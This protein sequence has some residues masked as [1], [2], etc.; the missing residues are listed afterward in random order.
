MATGEFNLSDEVTLYAEA[1]FN[2][3]ESKH[4]YLTQMWGYNYTSNWALHPGGEACS[5]VYDGN[6][7]DC[8]DYDY[9]SY[10]YVDVGNGDP[11][12]V[13]WT[14]IFWMAAGGYAQ[15][16]QVNTQVDYSR[17][18]LGSLGEIG[19][20]DWDFDVSFQYSNSAGKY[21]DQVPLNDAW[22][23][24]SNTVALWG[25]NHV[26]SCEGMTFDRY[27]PDGEIREADIACVDFN[28]LDPRIMA[29]NYTDE[30]SAFMFAEEKGTTDYTNMAL[31]IGFTNNELFT[32]Y[33]G[34]IGLAVGAQFM[35]DE[36]DDTPG[37][38]TLSCN[39]WN[40]LPTAALCGYPTFGETQTMAAYAETAIPLLTGKK[41]FDYLELNASARWT[42]V[43]IDD[44]PD[45]DARD[46]DDTTYK[47]GLN[48]KISDYFRF[49]AN[50]GTSFRTPALF[51][52]YRKNFVSYAG[53]G[54]DPCQKW[55]QKLDD[56]SISER[57]AAN[58]ASE[59]I[60]DDIGSLLSMEVIT[61]GGAAVLDPETATSSTIGM[62]FAAQ[63][64]DFRM[65][66]DYW[67]L[68]VEDQ[69]GIFSAA[70]ILRGCYD[71][72]TYPTDT[73]CSL[74]ERYPAG[75]TIEAYKIDK[76]VSTYINLD[77][78]R[79]AGWDFEVNYATS[80]SNAWNL[81]IDGSATYV[82]VKETEDADGVKTS[83]LGRAGN[84]EWVGFLTFRL[85]K[86]PWSASWRINYVDSTDNNREGLSKTG[87][88]TL[89]DGTKETYYY[90]R[91]LDSRIYHNA[92]V[93]YWFGENRDWQALLTV[94][95][96]TDQKPP[97]ASTGAGISIQGY[98]A[99]YSQYDWKGRRWGLNIKKVF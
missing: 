72:D 99:F 33:A 3:R 20:S 24:S 41:G 27:G 53:Q 28:W 12:S 34:D 64:I 19:Q 38:E 61:G 87:S 83:R 31:D 5:Y 54:I 55:G 17:V 82:T 59:G 74:F 25:G 92:S 57:I 67:E 78:Q 58:C 30:Q 9:Y 8:V 85:D 35:S 40:G 21:Q 13:G 52:L 80:F 76:V 48:W 93:G 91:K 77:I 22:Q 69:I 63:D 43:S 50:I 15:Q 73:L 10:R 4:D 42:Q 98:G 68:E 81:T 47:V 32:W 71:S 94:T 14:G 60:P 45:S 16:G 23:N 96:L 89:T 44:T 2:R 46:F 62:V 36:I 26:G 65:S 86:G 97:R 39:V 7:G 37:I 11:R 51:E 6:W 88:W 18:V 56:G 90:S 1:L 49:R 29:G 95:N 66:V 84:P 79:T 75:D 70:G